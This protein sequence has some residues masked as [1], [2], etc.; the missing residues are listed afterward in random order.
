MCRGARDAW[1]WDRM[2]GWLNLQGRR[3]QMALLSTSMQS[4]SNTGSL[5]E[6][7]R[8]NLIYQSHASMLV[9]EQQNKH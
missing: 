7:T 5:G 4:M 9:N 2:G 1:E 8:E 3:L 6:G